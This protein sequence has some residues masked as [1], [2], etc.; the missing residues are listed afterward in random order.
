MKVEEQAC[1]LVGKRGE[2][3]SLKSVHVDGRLDGLMLQVKV[4]Q[5]YRNEAD[6]NI[7]AVYTFPLAWGATLLGM[8]VG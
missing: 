5:S 2:A 1:S 6:H 8:S 4:R 3:V 7:E